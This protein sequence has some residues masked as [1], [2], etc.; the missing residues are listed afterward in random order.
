MRVSLLFIVNYETILR[1][2][3]AIN[4]AG[5]DFLILDEAQR[6]KNHETKTAA[7]LKLLEAKHK[8]AITGTPIE[9][10]LIDVYS[11]MGILNSEFLSPL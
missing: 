8:L 6:A 5:I 1:D 3:I 2:R 11:I 7:S 9:N 10:K 4:N